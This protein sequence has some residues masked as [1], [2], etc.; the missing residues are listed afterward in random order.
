MNRVSNRWAARE[1][2][3]DGVP[4]DDLVRFILGQRDG[5]LD[6]PEPRSRVRRL[7]AAGQSDATQHEVWPQPQTHC[8]AGARSAVKAIRV[9]TM[10]PADV[11]SLTISVI[12]PRSHPSGFQQI[13]DGIRM[14]AVFLKNHF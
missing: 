9:R 6:G 11:W 2:E 7:E 10:Q 8:R 5:W 14:G 3:C 4:R 12:L 1:E 13:Q